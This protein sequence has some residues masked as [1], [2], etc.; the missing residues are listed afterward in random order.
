MIYTTYFA[1]LRKIPE[2]IKPISIAVQ[3]PAWYSGDTYKKLAPQWWFLSEWKKT[4]DNDYYI[5]CFNEHI[6]SKLNAAAV[7]N[8]LMQMSNGADVALVCYESPEKF[9]HRHL[10]AEWLCSNGYEVKEFS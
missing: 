2:N 5:K 10:I 3:T 8:E 6:L 9:C 7:Y 4:Q 1:K